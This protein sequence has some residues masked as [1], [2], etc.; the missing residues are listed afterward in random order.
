V[1]RRLSRR[2]TVINPDAIALEIPLLDGKPD[3]RRAGTMAIER[4]N[5][6]LAEGADFAIETTL[7]GMSALRL[8]G[9]AKDA[10]Y[11]VTVVYVGLSSTGL[12][13]LRVM[14]RVQ[15]GGHSV[16]VEA[17]KRRYPDSMAKLAHALALADRSYVFDNSGT[18]RRLLAIFDRQKIRYVVNDLPDWAVACVPGITT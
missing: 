6:L 18:R 11:K 1:S 13:V 3:E 10:D 16:P 17:L 12:S 8:I 9:A 14:D 4:R 15:Q 5:A 2:I 7:T